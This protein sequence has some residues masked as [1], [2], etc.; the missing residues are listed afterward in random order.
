MTEVQKAPAAVKAVASKDPRKI[1][2]KVMVNRMNVDEKNQHLEIVVNDLGMAGGRKSFY[3]GQEVE[4]TMVQI[5]ILK[6]AVERTR[7]DIPAGSGVYEAENPLMAARTQFPGFRAVSDRHTGMIYAERT[8]PN[9][10][11]TEVGSFL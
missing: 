8:R 2:K 4:L 10:T 9:Y 6:D 1:V 3:P 7:I 11:I 5:N